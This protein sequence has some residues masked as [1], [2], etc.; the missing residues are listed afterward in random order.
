[1]YTALCT[2]ICLCAYKL[3]II[4]ESGDVFSSL[5]FGSH[6]MD[7][8]FTP[9]GYCQSAISLSISFTISRPPTPAPGT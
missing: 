9:D 2:C 6:S 1:M 8:Q 3:S 4:G 7:A 5:T